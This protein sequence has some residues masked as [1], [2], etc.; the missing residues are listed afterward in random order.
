MYICIYTVH[1]NG[2]IVQDADKCTQ[3]S[4]WHIYLYTYTYLACI[5]LHLD[6]GLDL[7]GRRV[8]AVLLGL[9]RHEPHVRAGAHALGVK[10][11]VPLTELD[12]FAEDARVGAVRDRGLK[13]QE[14]HGKHHIS[15][16]FPSLCIVLHRFPMVFL[17]FSMVF[18]CCRP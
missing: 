7:E 11:A 14:S 13:N 5:G 10:G 9:L 15:H 18:R 2:Y 6:S 16:G 8:R 17:G 12:A 3:S 1:I 4:I